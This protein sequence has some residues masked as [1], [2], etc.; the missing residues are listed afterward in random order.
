MELFPNGVELV[1]GKPP[2]GLQFFAQIFANPR[3]PVA[4]L[5]GYNASSLGPQLSSPAHIAKAPMGA[6]VSIRADAFCLLG[7]SC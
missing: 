5:F 7:G 1:L 4:I 6:A 3:H 2:T